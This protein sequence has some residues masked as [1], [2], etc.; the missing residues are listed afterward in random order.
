MRSLEMTIPTD[1]RMEASAV[2]SDCRTVADLRL[3]AVEARAVNSRK[4]SVRVQ[5]E[6]QA[7][8]YR[9][10]PMEI[11]SGLEKDDGSVQ[12]LQKTASVV[13]VSD[14]GEKTFVVTDDYALPAGC[15]GAE[16]IL[17]QR[18]EALVED[19]KYV[20]GKAV[21][22]GRVRAWLTFAA[23]GDGLFSGR[24]ETEFS[25]IME[26]SASGAEAVPTVNLALTGVYFDLPE[27][28]EE[29][30]RVSA[31]IH[32]AAQAICRQRQEVAYI[33]DLYS[34]RTALVPAMSPLT[35][36]SDMGP[37][38]LR[39]TVAGRAEPFSGDGEVL[40]LTAAVG[41]IAVEE[42]TVRT[43]V[44]IRLISRQRDGQCT[45]ARCR[46]TAEF[47]ASELP[48]G[49]ALQAVTVTATDVYYA[50]GSGGAD[51]RVT[52]QM[53]GL[54]LVQTTVMAVEAVTEDGEAWEKEKGAPSVTLVRVPGGTDMWSLA[55]RYHSTMEAIAGANEGREEGLLLI[56]KGR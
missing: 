23:A 32:L 33:A 17:S 13:T 11:A 49:A 29:S 15:G 41:G 24:Y 6:A 19:V 16:R 4:V 21:F 7:Q 44:T 40:S 54:R 1:I 30:G 25:Q 22:R 28:G 10:Q 8:C 9:P 47:T 3:R 36:V 12:L 35:V 14:V 26:L 53:D 43:S 55:R 38:S 48:Q 18:V 46:L 42:N 51:V 20:S 52:L 2:D 37:V 31:E 50:P 34:N 45:A 5:V 27:R 56:P 39:Q